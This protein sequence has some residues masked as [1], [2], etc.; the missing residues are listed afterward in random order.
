[1]NKKV[2]TTLGIVALLAIIGLIGGLGYKIYSL[3]NEVKEKDKERELIEQRH[4]Q[5][6]KQQRDEI[7]SLKMSQTRF[8]TDSLNDSFSQE[9]DAAFQ[10]QLRANAEKV[11]QQM[12]REYESFI[13]E[14]Q[15][16]KQ[17]AAQRDKALQA[18]LER[19][20]Q[21]TQALLEE[22]RNTKATNTEEITRLR[23]EL[24]NLREILRSYIAQ[25]DSLNRQNQALHAENQSLR[26]AKSTVEQE[27]AALASEKAALTEKVA[28]AA[29]LDATGVSARGLN[30]KGKANDKVKD[31]K[32]IETHFNISRNVTAQTGSRPVYIR[33]T[34]PT[35]SVLTQ[36]GTFSYENRNLEY[37]I[38]REIEYTGEETP[39]TCYW[40]VNEA[41]LPG[42]YRV[43]I[44][45]DGHNIGQAS[46]SLR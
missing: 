15:Q 11:K 1:M 34:T 4:S 43:D 39:V 14:A 8:E 3:T 2:G 37:S 36:G 22:L 42:L 6:E 12:I 45:A 29:Q 38:R 40:D 35:G 33:I 9:S 5:R 46:F 23:N 16:L 25:V 31:V 21:R 17:Q 41:L 13:R 30:K 26:S 27:K 28:I 32:K 19:E 18:K 20:Q 24:A 7:D 44:F 10:E